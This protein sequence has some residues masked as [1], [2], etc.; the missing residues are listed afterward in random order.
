MRYYEFALRGVA[1]DI[2][3][4]LQNKECLREYRYYN[5]ICS[6]N[7]YMYHNLK[8]NVGF[9]AYRQETDDKILAVLFFDEKRETL[10]NAYDYIIEALESVF[11][12]KRIQLTPSEITMYEFLDCYREAQRRDF[13]NHGNR[14]VDLS[15][16]F[17]YEY[18]MN[19]EK[20]FHL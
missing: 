20:S 6:V 7:S 15:N 9:L 2:K 12:I 10:D 3:E 5:P 14:F 8:N 1:E 11:E 16:L 13:N 4:L 18:Y 17:I 19:N